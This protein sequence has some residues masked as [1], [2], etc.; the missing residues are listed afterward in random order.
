[1]NRLMIAIGAS[2]AA[3]AALL[4]GVGTASAQ[5]NSYPTL[6]NTR[7]M[8]ATGIF[9]SSINYPQTYGQ[10]LNIPGGF[11]PGPE[12]PITSL[13]GRVPGAPAAEFADAPIRVNVT[14]PAFAQL[15]FNGVLT[16]QTGEHRSFLSPAMPVDESYVYDIKA[17][18]TQD[19]QPVTWRRQYTVRAGDNLNVTIGLPAEQIPQ[20]KVQTEL[21]PRSQL[22]GTTPPAA[23]RPPENPPDGG[24]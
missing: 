8:P 9:M 12:L 23:N 4:V 13:T 6:Q 10:W 19:G 17:Q 3:A 22:P 14:L 1:M 11:V 7:P 20:P 24:R 21:R 2:L 5:Y 15:K 16:T 18:W